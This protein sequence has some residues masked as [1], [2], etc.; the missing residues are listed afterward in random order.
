MNNIK[1]LYYDKIEVINVNKASESKECDICPYC[2]FLN[3]GLKFQPN[4]CSVCHD[5]LM[6][7]MNLSNIAILNINSADYCCIISRISKSEAI[8]VM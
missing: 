7:S 2:Y 6:M 1:M 3:K 8:N 4:L 5:L